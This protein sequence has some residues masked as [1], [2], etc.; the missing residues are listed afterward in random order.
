MGAEFK[1]GVMGMNFGYFLKLTHEPR[2]NTLTWTLDYTKN[3]DFDDNV[4]HW[5]VMKHPTKAGWTRVLYSTKVKLFP[6]I[7]NL[8]VNF[9]TT[10]AL[11]ESTTWVKK[12]SEKEASKQNKMPEFKLPSW[13]QSKGGFIKGGATQE[14]TEEKLGQRQQ[15]RQRQPRL[16][17]FLQPFRFKGF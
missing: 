13:M 16:A 1:V 9:I 2:W 11:V 14:D 5:Q 15:Q 17:T 6:W 3:S 12:E 8:V 10:K 4:G 7:P